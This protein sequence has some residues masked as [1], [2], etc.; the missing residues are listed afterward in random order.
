METIEQFN[1]RLKTQRKIATI[2]IGTLLIGGLSLTL[3]LWN[4]ATKYPES[5]FCFSPKNHPCENDQIKRGIS[6]MVDRERR[7][8]TFDDNVKI[9]RVSPLG[10][11]PMFG[12]Y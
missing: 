8:F 5:L 7:N 2:A 12:N 6:W 10:I 9:L 1:H 4:D 11:M 3:P